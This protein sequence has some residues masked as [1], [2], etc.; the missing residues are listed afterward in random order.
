MTSRVATTIK[1]IPASAGVAF[2]PVFLYESHRLAVSKRHTDSV[3]AECARLAAAIDQA[4]K[5][6]QSLYERAR[7]AAGT[8]QAAIFEAH[9]MILEDPELL[10]RVT[11][12]VGREHCNAEYAWNEGTDY[13][14][15]ALRSISDEYLAARAADV[16]DVSRRVQ[17]ILQGVAQQD[18]PTGP[19]VIVASDLAPSDTVKFDRKKVLAF[20]TASGG[21]TSHVAILS[22]AL[23]IPAVVG[24]GLGLLKLKG[25][26]LVIVDGGAGEVLV[27]PDEETVKEYLIRNEILKTQRALAL[28]SAEQPA[29]TQNGTRF[30]VVANI[31]SPGDAADALKYGAEGVGL[32]RTEFLFLDRASAPSE[33]E[34]YAVYRS[35]LEVMEKRPVVIRTLDI[36]GDKPAPY[37][38]MPVE[39]NPFLGVRGAR[40]CLAHPE[41]FQDQ[42]RALLRAGEGHNLKIMAPMISSL[43]EVLALRKQVDEARAALQAKDIVYSTDLEVGIMVE[44]PS[45][46]IMA[47]ALAPEVDFF[48]IGT[49]DLAQYT[50]AADRTNTQLAALADA[51]HPA[52]LRLIRTVVE[53]AHSHGKWVGLCGELAGDPLATPVLLGLGVDEFSMNSRA[54]PAVKQAIRLYNLDETREI[55]R[56]ALSLPTAAE[57]RGYL[58]SVRK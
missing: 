47:D 9:Q 45:A 3:D 55:A 28:Q 40:L 53:A 54:I 24:L 39:L 42:L 43:E 29:I 4:K 1:G 17:R 33:D 15:D 21:P 41:L 50:L 12:T 5:E 26:E 32:L 44:V 22:R 2:G 13:Y 25:G 46:A 16:E 6:L 31:G 10:D 49:N 37:L 19:S 11:A 30:E 38:N 23:G 56:R 7:D 27:D 36:G 20:C 58:E 51:F 34:Q 35:V 48:S 8:D 14:A 57:V 18:D 52:V